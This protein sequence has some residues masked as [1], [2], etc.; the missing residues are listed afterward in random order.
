MNTGTK[1]QVPGVCGS[2]RADMR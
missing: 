1:L 2:E